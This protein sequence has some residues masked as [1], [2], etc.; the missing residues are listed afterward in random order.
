MLCHVKCAHQIGIRKDNL[1]EIRFPHL[2]PTRHLWLP[3]LE[4]L[5]EFQEELF[6]EISV[7]KGVVE[8]QALSMKEE[9]SEVADVLC[10]D[11]ADSAG[12]NW[13]HAAKRRRKVKKVLVKTSD[14]PKTMEMKN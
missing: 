8:S 4:K 9:L 3:T 14:Q 7:M 6:K 1:H 12:G 2:A 13:A 11:E 10:A 5:E